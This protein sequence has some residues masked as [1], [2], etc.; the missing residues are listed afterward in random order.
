MAA[1]LV[2]FLVIG[3]ALPVLPLHVHDDLG[4]S[5]FSVG[6]VAGAQFAA[7]VFTRIWAGSLADEKGGKSAVLIGL[8]AAALSG[9]LYLLSLQFENVPVLSITILIVGRAVLGGA[10]SFVITGGISW[11]LALVVPEHA[12]KIIAWVGTAMFAALAAGGPL[13]T[14]LFAQYG[15]V[16]IAILTSLLPLCVIILLWKAAVPAH[17]ATG[18]QIPIRNIAAAVWLPGASLAF[19]SIGYGAILAFSSLLYVQESWHPVWLAFTAFSVAL[20]AARLIL[21]HLPDKIGGAKVAGVCMLVQALG[22]ILMWSAEDVLIASAGA[23]LAG[24]GYSL[25]F[26]GLGLEAVRKV[27]PENRGMA[28]GV[29]TVFLDVAMAIG[30]PLLGS[31]ADRSGVSAVFAIGAVMTFVAAA[32]A[33]RL[34]L[35]LRYDLDCKT[36]E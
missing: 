6:L 13:G 14:M 17:Q 24:F 21:G 32:I 29:Y 12:G 15:F 31:V 23:A 28:M 34:S 7:S 4:F 5:S 35:A 27:L 25:I 19:S 3:A 33:F 18:T 20:I 1:V 10:E 8:V 2:G 36:K 22:L 9:L 16:A 26:P 30:S 11:G